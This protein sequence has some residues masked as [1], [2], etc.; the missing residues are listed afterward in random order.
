MSQR[1]PGDDRYSKV[2][3]FA[4]GIG[5]IYARIRFQFYLNW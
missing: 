3:V 5:I 4:L 2:T 1:K